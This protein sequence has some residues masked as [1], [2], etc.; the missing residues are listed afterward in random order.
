MHARRPVLIALKT[1]LKRSMGH[2]IFYCANP[3]I[4]RYS[5]IEVP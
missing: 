4:N 3:E 2:D 5:V 1:R